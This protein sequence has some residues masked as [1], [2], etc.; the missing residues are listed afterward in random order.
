[1]TYKVTFDPAK[2]QGYANCII[3][4]PELFDFDEDQNLAILLVAH[5]DESLRERA[6]AA[7]RGCPAHAIGVEDEG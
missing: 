2:C 4:A 5:P 3:E 6:K 7:E 1:M